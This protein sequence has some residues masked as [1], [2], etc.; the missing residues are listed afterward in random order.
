M[1][2]LSVFSRPLFPWI[3]PRAF[4]ALLLLSL[5]LLPAC[6]TREQPL[7][8]VVPKGQSHVFW[9]SVHAGAVAAS[10]ESGVDI[11]WNGPA[12]ETDFTKQIAIIDAFIN[13]RVDGILLAPSEQEALVPAI[14]RAHRAGI[15]LTIFDSRAQTEDYVS[16]IATDNYA[17]GVMGARRLAKILGGR[18][19]VAMIAV[20]PGAASTL[21][22]EKGFQDTLQKESPDIK[23]V[24]WQYGMAEYARSLTVTEDILTAHPTVEGIF[25]SNESSTVGA[26]QA[27]KGRGLA[28][29]V[30]IVGFDSSPSLLD[31][32]RAGTI[33][34]LVLQDPFQM[35]YLGLKTLIDYR[36]GRE[37][38][39]RTDLP[40]T[41]VTR[42]NLDDSK[43]QR[44]VNP[45]IERYL[46][47]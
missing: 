9:Q 37:P 31:D 2:D 4:Q 29:K 15:P 32:L 13:R 35:G 21:E 36:A 11:A 24:A 10:R 26:A 43:I 17:G 45:D 12:L 22:R 41:L 47:E 7:Y 25:A 14:Q 20:M 16:F 42:E 3:S 46:K 33:D 44:L 40:P 5:L 1:K 8:A 38:P 39:K 6:K 28:G 27:V 30:K 18:G 19:R 23:L 34:S